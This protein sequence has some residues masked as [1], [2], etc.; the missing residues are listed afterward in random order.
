[1]HTKLNQPPGKKTSFH[2]C[3]G[4]QREWSSRASFLTDRQ[5]ALHGYQVNFTEVK[6]GWF[7]FHHLRE[8]CNTTFA[9]PVELFADLYQGHCFTQRLEGASEC[10]RHCDQIENLEPCSLSCECAW[11]REVV[12]IIKAEKNHPLRELV[13]AE[14]E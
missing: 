8:T 14:S 10:P 3:S 6:A 7:L 13:V 4:C 5:T 12:Q 9:L 1:M 2:R 11:A